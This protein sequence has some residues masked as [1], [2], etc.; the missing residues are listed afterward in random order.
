M[1]ARKITGQGP[2]ECALLLRSIVTRLERTRGGDALVGGGGKISRHLRSSRRGN[3]SNDP[4]PAL[5]V[6]E[7]GAGAASMVTV[8]PNELAQSLT[9]IGERLYV[10]P[11]G[12]RVSFASCRST[13][14]HR[15]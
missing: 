8:S 15:L 6:G 4:G 11:G 13:T 9:D 2:V 3:F 1:P 7:H 5:L 14:P 12:G 10:Q